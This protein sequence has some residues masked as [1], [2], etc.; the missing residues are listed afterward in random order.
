MEKKSFLH[1]LKNETHN[2]LLAFLGVASTHFVIT[3]IISSSPNHSIDLNIIYLTLIA[4]SLV[5]VFLIYFVISVE[6]PFSGALSPILIL[7]IIISSSFY[8]IIGGFLASKKKA[9][10]W[11]G[12]IF[13]GLLFLSTCLI[14]YM[15]LLAGGGQ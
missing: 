3:S 4:P 11:T 10:R 6:I 14:T 5:P 1:F 7:V 15:F 12:I 8:G 9:L 2:V 13:I